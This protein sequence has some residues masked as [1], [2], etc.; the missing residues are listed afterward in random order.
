MTSGTFFLCSLHALSLLH[1][2][3]QTHSHLISS[4]SHRLRVRAH[5]FSEND[6]GGGRAGRRAPPQRRTMR[7]ARKPDAGMWRVA[8]SNA[9]SRYPRSC[10]F[11]PSPFSKF[12]LCRF[13]FPPLSPPSVHFLIPHPFPSSLSLTHPLLSLT[14][15]AP[16]PPPPLL[17]LSFPQEAAAMRVR[18]LGGD[19]PDED[20][21]CVLWI[22]EMTRGA[23]IES[24]IRAA[25]CPNDCAL[26]FT[27]KA[28]NPV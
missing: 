9:L 6:Q 11:M 5:S 10:H 13:S 23:I 1:P 27:Q 2:S 3:T 17:P 24:T 12:S 16:A 22:S 19:I 20:Q 25:L 7:F 26:S 18:A 28:K 4:P 14:Y 8:V 15:P 21:V